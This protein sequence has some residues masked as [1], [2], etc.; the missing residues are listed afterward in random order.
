MKTDEQ[1][2]RPDLSSPPCDKRGELES[3]SHDCRKD[4]EYLESDIDLTAG[5]I[6][7]GNW[8]IISL[9]GI[10]GMGTVFRVKDLKGGG[11]YA[12]K[13]LHSRLLTD[14]GALNRFRQE[15]ELAA[16]LNHPNI[17]RSHCSGVDEKQRPYL[18]TDLLD[19]VTL[20]DALE[21]GGPLPLEEALLVLI[22]ISQALQ[23]AHEMGVIH[24][25]LKPSNVMLVNGSDGHRM[26][27]LV[28]FGIAKV[29]PKMGDSDMKLTRTGDVVGSPFY[30][31]PEQC[32]A[33]DLDVR[34]DIYSMGCLIY[35]SFTARPPFLNSNV[36]ETYYQHINEMPESISKYAPDLKNAS[37][38]DA[39]VCKCM[40]K[41][42]ADRYQSMNELKDALNEL[43][44][45]ASQSVLNKLSKE[46]QVLDLKIKAT[47]ILSS[48]ER[49]RRGRIVMIVCFI[50]GFVIMYFAA[51]ALQ[52]V[53][54]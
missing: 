50:I 39:I 29:L 7:G 52:N 48:E 43:S 26:V 21:Q 16:K 19:G 15:A 41:D 54:P 35:A 22:Q 49:S 12:I 2:S 4:A 27:K 51:G 28:D 42:P 9:L 24:R 17:N 33:L 30:M 13:V 18:V 3:Q 32:M 1:K 53:L 31:S 36:Y 37:A 23:H 14:R 45:P 34:S 47:K 10:G 6:I 25:D 5:D 8:K 46:M 40:A 11:E 44:D 20:D 38:I